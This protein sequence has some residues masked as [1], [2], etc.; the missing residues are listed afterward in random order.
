MEDLKRDTILNVK[1]LNK[2]FGNKTALDNIN[3]NIV[4]NEI[5]GLVGHNGAGKTSFIKSCCGLLLPDSGEITILDKLVNYNSTKYLKDI[6][7]VL[8]GNRNIYHNMTVKENINYFGKLKGLNNAM[9]SVYRDELL[10]L[11]KLE[12]KIDEVVG[13]LSRGM[14]QKVAICCSIIHKPKLLF[15]DEPTLGL[16]L[17]SVESVKEIINDLGNSETTIIITSHDLQL[18]SDITDRIIVIQN[19]KIIFD[20]DRDSI[21]SLSN[22]STLIIKMKEYNQDIEKMHYDKILKIDKTN[23]KI[24][25]KIEDNSDFNSIFSFLI[26]NK[27]NIVDIIHK[28]YSLEDLYIDLEGADNNEYIF[29]R[30][31]EKI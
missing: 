26:E 8:E 22:Y 18:I 3:L 7:A 9:I 30:I 27:I 1:S 2:K 24:Y 28:E 13:S 19:G 12:N 5:I 16:D 4:K 6:G 14:Q 17:N 10:R 31:K 21:N 25:F 20:G 11:F 15:L 23:N 29:R